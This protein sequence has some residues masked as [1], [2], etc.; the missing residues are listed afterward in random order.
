MMKGV[1]LGADREAVPVD[2][3]EQVSGFIQ[4]IV[5]DINV[6]LFHPLWTPCNTNR[7]VR[8]GRGSLGRT[9]RHHGGRR[10]PLQ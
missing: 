9:R 8:I 2:F 7:T 5:T 3:V 4:P 6:R 10:L 1:S